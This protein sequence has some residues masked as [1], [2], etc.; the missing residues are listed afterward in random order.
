MQPSQL[1][2]QRRVE[3][4]RDIK[5]CSTPQGGPGALILDSDLPNPSSPTSSTSSYWTATV[6]Q[7]LQDGDSS[8]GF[9]EGSSSS[10]ERS[11]GLD[12]PFHI[13]WA[14]ARLHP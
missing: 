4:L 5:R 8:G 12:G 6:P 11:A 14:P 7:Q 9:R 3:T 2:I 13:F 1:E 10:E